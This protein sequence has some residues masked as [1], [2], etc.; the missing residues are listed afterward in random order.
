MATNDPCLSGGCR[1]NAVTHITAHEPAE[2]RIG[3]NCLFGPDCSVTSSD[4]HKIFDRDTNERL[5]P[6]GDIT[7]G[8]RVWFGARAVIFHKSRIGDDSVVG[9]GSVVKGEF[10][11]NVMLAGA[12]ARVIKTGIRWEP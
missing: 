7:I 9:W 4:V 11:A 3:N 1:F 5:N 8:N 2:I 10:P 12:P 6:A